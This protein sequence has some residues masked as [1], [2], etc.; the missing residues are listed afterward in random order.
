MHDQAVCRPQLPP[1]RV[2]HVQVTGSFGVKTVG[3]GGGT[4]ADGDGRSGRQ[5]QPAQSQCGIHL[6]VAINSMPNPL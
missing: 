6:T 2:K 1:S 4:Q 3:S 5:V